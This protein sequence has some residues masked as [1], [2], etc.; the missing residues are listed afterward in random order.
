MVEF[1]L[2][3]F[4]CPAMAVTARRTLAKVKSSAIRPRQPDVPNLMGEEVMGLYSSPERWKK[5][6]ERIGGPGRWGRTAPRERSGKGRGR[7]RWLQEREA[8]SCW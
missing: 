8:D 7:R 2:W 5:K 4:T 1:F 3:S 6:E